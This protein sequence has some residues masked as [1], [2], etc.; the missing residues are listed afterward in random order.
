VKCLDRIGCNVHDILVVDR[1][2]DNFYY[3]K[4]SGLALPW[5]AQRKDTKLI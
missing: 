5:R 1:S 2:L 3:N 4:E